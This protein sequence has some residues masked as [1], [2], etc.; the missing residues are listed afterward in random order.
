MEWK[1]PIGW[2]RFR[3]ENEDFPKAQ[4]TDFEQYKNETSR[5]LL[6]G[7]RDDMYK[8]IFEIE[9]DGTSSIR[10]FGYKLSR[11]RW[12]FNGTVEKE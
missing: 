2:R 12:W 7:N 10:K 11:S 9:S 5:P 1:I 8:Q 4:E 3:Y 6:I